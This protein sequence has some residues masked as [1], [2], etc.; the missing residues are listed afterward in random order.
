MR[1][2]IVLL[3]VVSGL[4]DVSGRAL[5]A[6]GAK[7]LVGPRSPLFQLGQRATR[8][9][10]ILIYQHTADADVVEFIAEL[11]SL[12]NGVGHKVT[13][14][15]SEADLRDVAGRQ[16][17]N[18]VMMQ[19]DAARRLRSDLTSW[20]NGATILPMKEYVPG[21]EAARVKKEFGHLLKLPTTP[22][23]LLSVVRAA[24]R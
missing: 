19:L 20:S 12:L 22:P 2:L 23:D 21:A 15:T 17:F 13:I 1:K 14:V 11:R 5:E 9:A 18:V 8:P 3:A 6:C 4:L 16:T 10:T 24:H 7:F